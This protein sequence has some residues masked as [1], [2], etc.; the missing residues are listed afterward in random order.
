[1]AIVTISRQFGAGGATLGK[2]IAERLKYRFVSSAILNEIAKEANVS[3]EWVKSVD[4]HAGDWLMRFTSKLITLDMDRHVGEDKA[5][6]DEKRFCLFLENILPKIAD[7]D[8]AIIIGR[9]SQFILQNHPK[10]F[11]VLLVADMEDR[12]RFLEKHW[13]VNQAEAK[14]TIQTRRKR[15]RMFLKNFD[16]REPNDPSIYHITIN[17]SKMNMEKAEELVIWMVDNIETK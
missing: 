4:K 8:N 6:F 14:K 10:T 17:T 15:R 7:K 2:R 11:H 1:M 9:G 12:I 5:D 16:P 3:V 13:N